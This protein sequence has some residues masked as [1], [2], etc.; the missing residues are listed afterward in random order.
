MKK[1]SS[2]LPI[3]LSVSVML[4]SGLACNA[5]AQ[6]STETP[7]PVPGTATSVPLGEQVVLSTVSQHETSQSPAYEIKA[8]LPTLQGSTD[9]RVLNFNTKMTNLVNGETDAFKKNVSEIAGDPTF[10]ASSLDVK[11]T[12][13][14]QRGDI[15][16]F[17]FDFSFYS[18]GAAHPGRYSI[19]VNYDLGQ[20]KELALAD[21]FLPSANYLEA[22]SKYCIAE[23]SKQPFFDGPFSEGAQPTPENYRNWNITPNGLMITF[24]EYQVGPYAAGPQQVVVPYSELKALINPQG[25]LGK[26]TK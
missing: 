22:I 13:T 20:G 11:Y 6:V 9:S 24:D 14:F 10:A 17:K 25:P 2:H 18:S 23:L 7:S 15:F 19:T 1:L 12:L 16:S 5:L 21:L 26:V 4:L 3:A 8:D